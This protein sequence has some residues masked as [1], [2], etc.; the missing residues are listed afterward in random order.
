[1]SPHRKAL[2]RLTVAATAICLSSSAWAHPGH[3]PTSGFSAGL[4]HPLTGLDHLLAMVA[5]GLFAAT[6]GRR[7]L[8]AVPLSFMSL[9][10]LGGILGMTGVPLPFVEFAIALSVLVLGAVVVI[11]GRWPVTMAM[12][13]VGLF[14]VFHGYAHGA[15]MPETI[16]AAEYGLGFMLATGALHLLGIGLG[17]LPTR[18]AGIHGQRMSQIG[19]LAIAFAGAGL[20]LG[21]V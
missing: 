4:L 6:L 5:V 3:L 18:I 19:G 20:L 14:A 7:A 10:A 8:W 13:L 15:E 1:M 17:V 9:M 21:V 2:V 12:M 16:S 11:G